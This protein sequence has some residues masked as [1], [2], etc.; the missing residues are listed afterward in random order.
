MNLSSLAVTAKPK[1]VSWSLLNL[2]LME[3]TGSKLPYCGTLD[4]IWQP[5]E[6]WVGQPW[7]SNM[8]VI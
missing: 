2:C 4:Y 8:T 6:F 7:Q 5:L 3:T 1:P